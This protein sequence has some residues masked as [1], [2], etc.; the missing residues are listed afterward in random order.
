MLLLMTLFLQT[1][2][3]ADEVDEEEKQEAEQKAAADA[4]AAP[5]D[6]DGKFLNALKLLC[7]IISLGLLSALHNQRAGVLNVA[8]SNIF[9]PSNTQVLL[10]ALRMLKPP[11]MTPTS[12]PPLT[13]SPVSE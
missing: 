4:A 9:R 5:A 8:S 11:R 13:P 10:L 12:L 2:N 1:A 7:I 3:W 6:E